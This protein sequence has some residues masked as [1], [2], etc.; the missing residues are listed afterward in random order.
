MVRLVAEVEFA[1]GIGVIEV[2]DGIRVVGINVE[3][4]GLHVVEETGTEEVG[5]LKELEEDEVEV[6][7]VVLE[8]DD[9][10]DAMKSNNQVPHSCDG[11]SQHAQDQGEGD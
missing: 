3:H 10:E 4:K 7:V 9:A 1:D 5:F 11:F 6:E 8:E 2:R